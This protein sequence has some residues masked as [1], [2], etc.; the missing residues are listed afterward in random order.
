MAQKVSEP[1]E[2]QVKLLKRLKLPVL[3]NCRQCSLL[4]SFVLHGEYPGKTA[5][6]YVRGLWRVVGAEVKIRKPT[7]KHV[8]QCGIV[9]ELRM[10]TPQA[11][12]AIKAKSKAMPGP[13]VFVVQIGE[14]E[15]QFAP[16]YVK[17]LT[18]AAQKRLF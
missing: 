5:R 17:V 2:A 7:S 14:K 15:A 12:A 18:P 11:R 16:T 9:R 3:S 10:R 8:G 6:E 4:I 13:F 1:S